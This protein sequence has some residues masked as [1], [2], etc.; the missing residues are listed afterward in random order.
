MPARLGNF[1][2]RLPAAMAMLAILHCS[3]A[4]AEVSDQPFGRTF[5][6]SAGAFI[7]NHDTNIRLDTEDR[8]GTVVNLEDDLGLDSTTNIFR[9]SA[10]WR[11][12]DR[13]RL[14]V[15]TFDLSQTGARTLSRDLNIEDETFSIN[16]SVFTD[17]KMQLVELGYSYRIRG[18]ERTQ[19]WLD[20]AFFVQDTAV[21]V[22]ETATGGD[23]S[24]EDVVLPL[25]KFGISVDHAFNTRWIG[26]A[27]ID[28]FKLEIGDVGGSLVDFRAT[29][30]YRITDN[31][32][33]GAG[34]HLINV[35]VN[36]DRPVSGW[37]GRL[38]WETRGLMAYGRLIW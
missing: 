34:W 24:S 33:V 7:T 11:F 18:N 38:D 17:W 19:W 25:P 31:F 20:F 30:D 5:S 23:V 15:G 27:G 22:Q 1:G 36:L 14:H 4:V 21:T 9:A 28:V 16:E 10:H 12:A 3:V 13:H 35:T 29:L 2:N 37:Q 32:S 6:I 26:H 8:Q